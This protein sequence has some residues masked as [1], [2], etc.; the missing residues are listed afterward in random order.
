M[1]HL[2]KTTPQQG[3]QNASKARRPGPRHP[4]AAE[5]QHAEQTPR[6]QQPHLLGQEA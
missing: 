3:Y 6:R 2:D 1:S 5:Q 4:Y